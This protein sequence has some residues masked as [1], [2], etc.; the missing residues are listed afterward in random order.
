MIS[1]WCHLMWFYSLLMRSQPLA[2]S[3]LMWSQKR[4]D[5][6]SLQLVGGSSLFSFQT[7]IPLQIK[8]AS[9]LMLWSTTKVKIFS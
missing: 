7:I 6:G 4:D 8:A 1:V 2:Y 5:F 9:Q 3:R